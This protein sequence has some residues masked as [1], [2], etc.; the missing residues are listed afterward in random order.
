VPR[1]RVRCGTAPERGASRWKSTQITGVE[2]A[3]SSR[4]T[5]RWHIMRALSSSSSY[6]SQFLVHPMIDAISL[7]RVLTCEVDPARW[8]PH[9]RSRPGRPSKDLSMWGTP[10]PQ[11]HHV[12]TRPEVGTNPVIDCPEAAVEARAPILP[13][14]HLTPNLACGPWRQ[15]DRQ[16]GKFY[17]EREAKIH[18][19][20][21]PYVVAGGLGSV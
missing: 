6:D 16:R 8:T 10:I 20:A 17:D 5:A 3:N 2:H 14:V 4:P 19:C 21:P 1:H 13:Q 18:W 11:D 12:V 7:Y 15:E 9:L